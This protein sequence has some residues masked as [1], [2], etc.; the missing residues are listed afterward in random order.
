ML[1]ATI[2]SMRREMHQPE[3]ANSFPRVIE[4][5]PVEI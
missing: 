2:Y 1:A 3:I 4:S 5:M